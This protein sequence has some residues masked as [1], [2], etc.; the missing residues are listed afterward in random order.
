[1]N[2]LLTRKVRTS[3]STIGTLQIDGVIECYILEDVDRGLTADM[4]LME[5]QQKKV[6]GL[7]AIPAGKY[8]VIVNYSNRFKRNL[9]L[10]LNVPGF[11]GIRIHPGNC[12]A[13]TEGCLLPGTAPKDNW[14]SNSKIAFEH[15]FQKII[16]AVN[17]QEDVFITIQ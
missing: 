16:D 9:P 15:L 13:D 6:F 1:M 14:V 10:L 12:A 17:R 4:S 11:D 7:T 8:R 3:Q 2:L 5:L